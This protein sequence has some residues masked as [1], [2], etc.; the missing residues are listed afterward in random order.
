[1]LIFTCALHCEAKPVI[2]F[3]R[4]KKDRHPGAFDVYKKED[5]ACV[6]TG[7]GQ[8]NMA[9]ACGWAAATLPGAQRL[10]INLGVAGHH[11]LAIGT[12]VLAL[13]IGGEDSERVFYPVA[14][15]RH[16]FVTGEIISQTHARRDYHAK[17]LYDME[18]WAYVNAVSHFDTLE[19][20]QCIKVISDNT[21]S[22]LNRDKAFISQL[23]EPHVSAI[24]KYAAQVELSLANR[25]DSELMDEHIDRFLALA[26]FTESERIQLRKLLPGLIHDCGVD[27]V[28]RSCQNLRGSRQ[29]LN[30]LGAA[31]H[32]AAIHL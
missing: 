12:P 18:A 1:M 20:C 10:W 17:A 4:L 19:A 3:Y 15:A 31:L 24:A 9:T 29:I 2:D 28:Y 22:E 30:H 16:E 5:V 21:T 23:I 7:I 25:P 13:K 6:V 11:D 26:H 8:L 32:R 27:E 14:L